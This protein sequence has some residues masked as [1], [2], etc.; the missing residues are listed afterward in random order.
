A[1]RDPIGDLEAGALAGVLELADELAG[2][3]FGDELRG[4][5]CVEGDRHVAIGGDGR[6]T[7]GGT[8]QDDVLERERFAFDFERLT[9]LEGCD[10]VCGELS[11]GGSDGAELLS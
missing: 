6:V 4:E 3:P 1:D 11:E 10:G 2:V 5:G 9:A 7:P 8:L